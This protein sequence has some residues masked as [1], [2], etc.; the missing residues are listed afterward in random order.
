MKCKVEAVSSHVPQ[1]AENSLDDPQF[2]AESS[3]SCSIGRL[4]CAGL[5]P[6]DIALFP[7][8]ILAFSGNSW[9]QLTV[10]MIFGTRKPRAELLFGKE[11]ACTFLDILNPRNTVVS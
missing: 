7:S 9:T 11:P 3:P 1:C 8:Q 4:V 6:S 2:A 10:F 5:F